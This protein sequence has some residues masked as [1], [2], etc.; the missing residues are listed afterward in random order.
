MEATTGAAATPG[1]TG[2]AVRTRRG[3]KR[4][5]FQ[6]PTQMP[7]GIRDL[8]NHATVEE[9]ERAHQ[10][11]VVMLQVW[12]AKLTRPEAAERL[13]IPPVRLHQ[14]SQQATAGMLAGL[15]RQPRPRRAIAALPAKKS[16]DPT[17]LKGENRRLE[18]EL[19]EMKTLVSVLRDL[20]LSRMKERGTSARCQEPGSRPSAKTKVRKA[21]SREGPHGRGE[22]AGARADGTQSAGAGEAP[23]PG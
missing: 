17:W 12:M 11:G 6:P 18:Q 4:L 23:V 10:T 8:W 20:P 7:P 3:K 9:R 22:H 5:V 1:V 14:L 2:Q 15:L 13:G 19:A 21:R 16:E